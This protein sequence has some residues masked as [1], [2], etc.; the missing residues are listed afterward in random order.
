MEHLNRVLKSMLSS[1]GANV[2]P[3]TI[4]KAGRCVQGVHKVCQTFRAETTKNMVESDKH[5][6]PAFTKCNDYCSIN[7]INNDIGTVASFTS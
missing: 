7:S 5:P 4:V 6:Y 2:N 3:N 1:V